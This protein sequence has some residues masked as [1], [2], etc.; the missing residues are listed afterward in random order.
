MR[1]QMPNNEISQIIVRDTGIKNLSR[2][3]MNLAIRIWR[4]EE[5]LSRYAFLAKRNVMREV[6]AQFIFELRNGADIT[7]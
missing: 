1:H 5:S 4:L 2:K 6:K 7:V 3:D